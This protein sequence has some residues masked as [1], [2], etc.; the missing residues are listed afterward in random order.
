MNEVWHAR[1][2]TVARG[3]ARGRVRQRLEAL[4]EPLDLDG[5]VVTFDAL[6]TV[7]ANLA[8]LV[9]DKKPATSRPSSATS[10]DAGRWIRMR[11]RNSLTSAESSESAG[12][13]WPATGA[14]RVQAR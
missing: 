11:W 6:H 13:R 14:V 4:P 7:R 10:R 8:W 3:R 2:G 12:P 1:S 5:A 9:T